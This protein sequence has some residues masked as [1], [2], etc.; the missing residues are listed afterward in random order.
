MIHE[1]K[2]DS[3]WLDLCIKEGLEIFFGS[4]LIEFCGVI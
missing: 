2:E 3:V 4:T 1:V